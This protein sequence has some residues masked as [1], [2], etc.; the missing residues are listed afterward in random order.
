ML[1]VR[2]VGGP[3]ERKKTASLIKKKRASRQ[4]VSPLSRQEQL[5]NALVKT[6]KKLGEI[7]AINNEVKQQLVP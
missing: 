6:L 4:I 5:P 7:I 1:A 2:R 3:I